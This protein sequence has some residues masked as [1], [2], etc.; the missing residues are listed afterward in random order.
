MF[1]KLQH[2]KRFICFTR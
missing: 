1:Q 2:H